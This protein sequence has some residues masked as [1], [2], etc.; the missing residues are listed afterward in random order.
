[1]ATLVLSRQLVPLA[2]LR[3][4]LTQT[5]NNSKRIRKAS[6]MDLPAVTTIA[7]LLGA[8]IS[9]AWLAKRV[10]GSWLARIPFFF[11]ISLPL[12]VLG[13]MFLPKACP[14]VFAKLLGHSI[15][16]DITSTS[17]L[18]GGTTVT[19]TSAWIGEVWMRRLIL[20]LRVL[21]PAGFIL[22]LVNLVTN[23]KRLLNTVACLAFVGWI[24]FTIRSVVW[25]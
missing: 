5:S 9:T 1:M 12:F 8:T 11:E 2:R 20:P 7:F 16:M 4:R 24:I 6:A 3:P 18:S 23:K 21:L 19:E 10:T 25:L 22:G 17:H 13:L 14:W 15:D